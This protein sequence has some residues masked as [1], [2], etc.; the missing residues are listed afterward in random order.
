MLERQQA[1][2]IAGVQSLHQMI[3]K[4]E[5]LPTGALEASKSG[6][7]L[8]H[9]ILQS[10]GVLEANDP[11]DEIDS[12]GYKPESPE[13][14]S[15]EFASAI[16]THFPLEVRS[17]WPGDVSACSPLETPLVPSPAWGMASTGNAT[18]PPWGSGPYQSPNMR[19]PRSMADSLHGDKLQIPTF[20][21]CALDTPKLDPATQACPKFPTNLVNYQTNWAFDPGDALSMLG[22]GNGQLLCTSSSK[23]SIDTSGYGSLG[24]LR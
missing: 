6:L 19:Q 3:Q 7:P 12:E 23:P 9:Q 15:P 11:W 21:A 20:A 2:L 14:P 1:Q 24:T 18:L 8:V 22:E 5:R 4:G 13:S 10:L 17:P 16:D